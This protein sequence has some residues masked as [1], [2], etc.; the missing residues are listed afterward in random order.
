VVAHFVKTGG[1][2]ATA[3]LRP[4]DWIREID[5]T[6]VKDFAEATGRLGA[7]EGDKDRSEFVLLVARGSETAV[8]RVK[9]K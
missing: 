9:L 1:P 2:S 4:D 3:G 5:G 6:E 8:L 7:I